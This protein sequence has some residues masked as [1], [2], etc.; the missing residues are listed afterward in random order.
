MSTD[1]ELDALYAELPTIDCQG[2]CWNSCGPIHMTGAE[3]QR[4]RRAGVHI[5]N[6]L[7]SETGPMTCPALTMFHQCGVYEARPLICRMWGATRKLRCNYGCKP[8]RYLTERE[9]VEFM[10]RAHEIAGETKEAELGR[11]ALAMPDFD[12]RQRQAGKVI[13][14]KYDY[15]LYRNNGGSI[16]R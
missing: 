7:Y 8:E 10:T 14:A 5:P 11:R 15:L 12:E 6:Q 2:H 13:D 16:T 1:D 3:Q 9:V 4:I